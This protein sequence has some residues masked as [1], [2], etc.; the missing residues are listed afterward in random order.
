MSAIH[1]PPPAPRVDKLLSE[2]G[3][4]VVSASISRKPERFLAAL[5]AYLSA[6][7]DARKAGA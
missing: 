6:L 2:V 1:T 4:A 7:L 5:D 3:V